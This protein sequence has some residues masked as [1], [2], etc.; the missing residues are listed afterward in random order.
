MAKT[1][2]YSAT[3]A[4]YPGD[5]TFGALL[6]WHLSWGTKPGRSTEERNEPWVKSHF[7]QFVHEEGLALKSATRS[8]RNWT[9]HG[10]LPDEH[11]QDKIDR[12]FSELFDDDQNLE[13]WKADLERALERGR[14]HQAARIAKRE[15][16]APRDV[17]R[18]TAHFIGRDDECDAL[19]HV[20][21][22][23]EASAVLIQG[24]PGIGKTELTKAIAHHPD[25]AARFGERRYFVPLENADTADKL[26]DA[27]THA[28]GFDPS[29]DFQAALGTLRDGQSLLVL[30][31]LE[32]PWE[33]EQQATQDT[34]AEL[35]PVP[36]LAIL[37]SIRG[38][39][40]VDGLHW[41]PYP[42]DQL[43]ETAAIDLFVSIAGEPLRG[44][45]H[46]NDF[47]RE[48]GGLPL[49]IQLVARR[50]HGQAS[51][52]LL[53]REWQRI[54]V[55]L[56]VSSNS[57]LTRF[58]SLSCSIELSIKSPAMTD[59]AL[60]VFRILSALPDGV[61]Q[62]ELPEIFGEESYIHI[63]LITRLSLAFFE[64]GTLKMLP[65]IRNFASQYHRP[66][67]SESKYW[68][69]YFVSLSGDLANY[70]RWGSF[71]DIGIPLECNLNNVESAFREKMLLGDLHDAAK[72]TD[73]M[74]WLAHF[75]GNFEELL[76]DLSDACL[77]YDSL[78][79]Y[80]IVNE[81]IDKLGR[82]RNYDWSKED[83]LG[84]GSGFR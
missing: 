4:N 24:G 64:R 51:L 40:F 30:D 79:D 65:P 29:Y 68:S 76:R 67:D 83:I 6:K 25:V 82:I 60:K 52:S 23:G 75:S 81:S 34:L 19:A 46:L 41:H 12:I 21:A 1:S 50:A 20:L 44:D 33:S 27:I 66:N 32:T 36:G 74:V 37:A 70:V 59:P 71:Y 9:E 54:G 17:P 56:A 73:A 3:L 61:Y 18:P 22:S 45:P 53:W 16:I 49:A 77:R 48:L 55:R 62:D 47:M 69:S 43:P 2:E 38:R 26:R 57:E 13:P 8:L 5:G 15:I 78:D 28:L 14:K 39:P 7:A 63:E 58:S 72:A 35:P 80:I 42:L 84:E 10:K 11:D 31:N